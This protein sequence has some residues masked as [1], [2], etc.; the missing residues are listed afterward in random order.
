V[1]D[2]PDMLRVIKPGIGA[3]ASRANLLLHELGHFAG[4]GHVSDTS[5]LINSRLNWRSPRG[6]A[7]GDRAGLAKVGRQSGC[8]GGF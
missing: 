3:G 7:A 6:Y 1:I 5:E 8:L 4:L 2:T